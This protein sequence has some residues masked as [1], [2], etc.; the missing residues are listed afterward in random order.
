MIIPAI[1]ETSWEEIEKKLLICKEFAKEIHIDFIDGKF[2]PNLS[3]LETEPFKKYSEQ[4]LLEAHLMVEEP[5]SYLDKLSG[6]GF[7]RF[8]GHIEKMSDQVEF[9]SKAQ[10]L[11]WVGL[12]LDLSTDLSEIKVSLEDLDRILLMSVK[13]G[14]SGQV[15][16]QSALEKIKELRAKSLIDIEVDGGIDLN[17][18]KL[19]SQAGANSFCV[20]SFLFKDHPKTQYDLLSRIV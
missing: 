14:E 12:A 18:L 6:S 20:N 13:A 17:T 3:F 5:I 8:I 15:F 19:A 2:S 9:V 4:F 1:L 11:G 7:K 16:D 10:E